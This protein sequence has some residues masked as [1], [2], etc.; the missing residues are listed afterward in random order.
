[1]GYSRLGNLWLLTTRGASYIK[2]R[3]GSD[4]CASTYLILLLLLCN[5][6]AHHDK[7]SGRSLDLPQQQENE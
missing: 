5:P 7:K 4:I 3:G 2:V 1:M 6:V